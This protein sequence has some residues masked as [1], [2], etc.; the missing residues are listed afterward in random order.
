MDMA[1]KNVA[2][3]NKSNVDI[4]KE[5][6]IYIGAIVTVFGI[7]IS[8]MFLYG[9]KV[10]RKIYS[11]DWTFTKERENLKS[12][13]DLCRNSNTSVTREEF[14][15]LKSNMNKYNKQYEVKNWI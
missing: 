13:L 10:Y 11:R 8:W 9:N 6:M 7:G 2:N 5:I 15:E 1:K 12:E 4:V 14:E 3:N